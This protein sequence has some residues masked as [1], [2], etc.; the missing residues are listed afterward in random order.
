MEKLAS[1]G[2]E[3]SQSVA[4]ASEPRLGAASARECGVH[5]HRLIER[6]QESRTV[7]ESRFAIDNGYRACEHR[8][9]TE[10][11]R[12]RLRG[13]ACRRA[14]QQLRVHR[15]GPTEFGTRK[16]RGVVRIE[17]LVD[18]AIRACAAR[19]FG[20]LPRNFS[21]VDRRQRARDH[22]ERPHVAARRV[23]TAD[24]R[25]KAAAKKYGFLVESMHA[26]VR[27]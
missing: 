5:R 8:A 15:V 1:V 10:G 11:R 16:A 3:P 12:D 26:R 13:R 19:E 20:K 6:T 25:G 23:R 14:E 21:R 27:R 2:C 4:S 22:R 7:R 17:A 18:A 24:S 9:A